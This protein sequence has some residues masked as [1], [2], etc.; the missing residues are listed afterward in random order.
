VFDVLL[1]ALLI[2]VVLQNARRIFDLMVSCAIAP[3]ALTAWIFDDYRHMFTKWWYHVKKLAVSPLV[4]SI[5][6]CLMGFL[7]FSTKHVTGAALFVKM[8]LMIGGLSRM[9]N[10]PSFVK[11]RVDDGDT[12]DESFMKMLKRMKGV[13]SAFDPRT[14]GSLMWGKDKATKANQAFNKFHDKKFKDNLLK[15]K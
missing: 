6:V 4:Y 3:L 8:L 10:P 15:T 7:I 1:I 13:K 14:Y 5:F 11:S 2:P 12:V 9:A